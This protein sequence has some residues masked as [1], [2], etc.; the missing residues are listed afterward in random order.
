M[1]LR[2]FQADTTPGGALYINITQPVENPQDPSVTDYYSFILVGAQVSDG[3]HDLGQCCT[4]GP[5][6]T[7]LC[8][9]ATGAHVRVL[10][11]PR[12]LSG[13]LMQPIMVGGGTRGSRTVRFG[14]MGMHAVSRG[15]FMIK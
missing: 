1:Q 15:R 10:H 4:P 2:Y 13:M 11:P 12:L 9:A 14:F 5:L 3:Q 6:V 8:R 7:S